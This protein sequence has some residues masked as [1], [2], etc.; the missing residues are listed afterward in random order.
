MDPAQLANE[1]CKRFEALH[2]SSNRSLTEPAGEPLLEVF[3]HLGTLDG[4]AKLAMARLA[5]DPQDAR[6]GHE[7]RR[8]LEQTARLHP[9]FNRRLTDTL[10]YRPAVKTSLTTSVPAP[11]QPVAGVRPA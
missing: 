11:A 10:A 8:I 4:W 2:A 3:N 9:H 6:A 1:A 7:L 5:G